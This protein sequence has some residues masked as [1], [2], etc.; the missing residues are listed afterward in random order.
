M[1]PGRAVVELCILALCST[2]VDATEVVRLVEVDVLPAT[3][4]LWAA[5]MQFSNAGF[6]ASGVELD[7][8]RFYVDVTPATWSGAPIGRESEGGVIAYRW[9]Q[10]A[11]AP[12]TVRFVVERRPGW[13][14]FSETKGASVEVSC[15]AGSAIAAEPRACEP[16]ALVRGLG[17]CTPLRGLAGA[18]ILA[19]SLEYFP[20]D[21]V[22]DGLP[23]FG[24]AR[25]DWKGES[26]SHKGLDIYVDERDVLAM[27]AGEVA[28]TGR[29]EKAGGWIKI[30]HGS[31]AE[32]VY[33]HVR[34]I[35]V[36]RGDT[37]RPGQRIGRI[38][39]PV[40]NAVEPQLHL[41][42]RI[43]GTSVDPAPFFERA[44]Q[45]DLKQAWQRA[46][47]S[48]PQRVGRREREIETQRAR[49]MN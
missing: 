45:A 33:V 31:G 16:V 49:D 46:I 2:A 11:A 22:H 24:A 18:D 42:I 41:E 4:T 34:R 7:G 6:E 19:R 47:S 38:S 39:G 40:G 1:R 23:H 5:T 26:R 29:G 17:L 43:D 12:P 27:A 36:S 37:V 21:V 32:T 48:I 3:G 14:C 28:G 10:F 44:S 35:F 9:G 30:A 20:K 15:R 8:T 25:D 13:R